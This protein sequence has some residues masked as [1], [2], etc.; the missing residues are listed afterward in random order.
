MGQIDLESN[1][2]SKVKTTERG[3]VGHFIGGDR[4]L[5][6]RN[7]LIE[8]KNKKWIIST[9]GLYKNPTTNKID[10][11]CGGGRAYYETKAFVAN[12]ENGYWEID[13]GKEIAFDN[14][15]AIYHCG[16][17]ADK[18]ADQLHDKIVEEL[19]YKIIQD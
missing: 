15:C 4:C 6:H 3:W 13:A 12:F 8:Y 9:V 18:E 19:K 10:I 7:T 5:Y 2:L 11:L 16:Y 1:M 14:Q 17:T